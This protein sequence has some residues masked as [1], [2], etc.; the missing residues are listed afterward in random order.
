MRFSCTVC[1][2]RSARDIAESGPC[3]GTY[4]TRSNN[5]S[6]PVAHEDIIAVL[7]PIRARAIADTFLT[8]LEFFKEAEI[9]WNWARHVL[10]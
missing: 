10:V 2:A 7:Q 4:M 8:L 5:G 6:I 9:S 1:S 3:A